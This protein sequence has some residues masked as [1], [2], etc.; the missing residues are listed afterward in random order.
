MVDDA[1]TGATIRES[2]DPPTLRGVGSAGSGEIAAAR[3]GDSQPRGAAV[4][5]ETPPPLPPP[6]SIES[7]PHDSLRSS[8]ERGHDSLRSSIER[9]HDSL[10]SS[11][12]RGHDSL[13]SSIELPRAPTSPAPTPPAPHSSGEPALRVP[14]AAQRYRFGEVLGVGGMG[15][16]VLAHDEHIDRDVAVKRIRAAQP[17]PEQLA[18]FMREARVQGGLEHPAVVPVHDLAIDS[19]GRPFFVMKRLSGTTLLALLRQLPTGGDEEVAARR[20]MLRAFV[21]VCLAIEFA[22]IRGIV[23]RDLKPA[24]IMLGD[25]GEVYVLDW[26]VARAFGERPAPAASA[27]ER[28]TPRAIRA[29]LELTTGETQVGTVLGTPACMAPEQLAGDRAGPAADIYALGC[30]LYEITAGE[31]W[32]TGP[33]SIGEALTEPAAR[34]SAKRPDVAPELDAACE[35]ATQAEPEARFS[36]ARAL[37]DAVQAFLDGDRD[38]AV[39]Q[40][41]ARHHIAEA[42]TALAHG[43]SDADRR[44]AMR[45]GGRALALDPTATEAA[46]LVTRLLLEP[47]R[48]VPEAVE[49]RLGRIDADTARHQGRIAAYAMLCYFGFVP[50]LLWSGIRDLRFVVA[51]VVLATASALQLHALATREDIAR[52]GI[53]INASVNALLIAVT[54]RMVGPFIIT[55]ALAMVTLMAYAAHPRFGRVH[56]LAII[57]GAGV[58]VPWALEVLGVLSPTYS[59]TSVGQLV[60]GSSILTFS[61]APVQLAFVALLIILLTVVGLLSRVLAQRQRDAT[62]RLELQAW[63]LEQVVPSIER[64]KPPSPSA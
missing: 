32:H 23:H 58:A 54:S 41:L 6:P 25:F 5:H 14:D 11:I 38:V 36:S 55:P 7:L 42:R 64:G 22:H 52:R 18:R 59:F 34:P 30:I 63:H 24:N 1:D 3:A 62:R 61:P 39:R 35:R 33:R 48:E 37:G 28:A 60:I 56:L 20:R 53:Y 8:I 15:E 46:E 57:L 47:P 50:L 17:S 51:F 49:D 2:A 44:A 16:V 12:E 27:G 21:D 26:G 13:R 19:D 31:P 43:E 40:A 9:G 29:G 10:R 45:A 4:A